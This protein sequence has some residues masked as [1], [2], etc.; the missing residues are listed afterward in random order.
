MHQKVRLR[1]AEATA[2]LIMVLFPFCLETSHCPVPSY[3]PLPFSGRGRPFLK[4]FAVV[5]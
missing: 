3:L 2:W 5:L 1:D 4:A